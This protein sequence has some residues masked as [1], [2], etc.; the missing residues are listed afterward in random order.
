MKKV[1]GKLKVQLYLGYAL[2]FM[3]ITVMLFS[4]IMLGIRGIMMSQIGQSRLDVLKQ[5]SERSNSIN[6]SI[7]TLSNL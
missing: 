2:T 6:N 5:I 7:I 4:V 1:F 3:V